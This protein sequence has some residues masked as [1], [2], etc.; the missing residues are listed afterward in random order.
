MLALSPLGR[1]NDANNAASVIVV[2]EVYRSCLGGRA[3]AHRREISRH[4]TKRLSLVC[5][6][7]RQS[8]HTVTGENQM[9]FGQLVMVAVVAAVVFSASQAEACFKK[10][11]KCCKP[12]CCEAAPTCCNAAPVSSCYAPAPVSTCCSA[13]V[14]EAAPCCA[15]APVAAPCCAPVVEAAPCCAPAPVSTCCD[16]APVSSCCAPAPVS[17]CAPAPSCCEPASCC[18]PPRQK[19]CKKQR[20]RKSRSRRSSCNSSPC[21]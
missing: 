21:C 6:R 2:F 18:K 17:C 13:P 7:S 16:V 12:V 15:P 20:C 14:V 8:S 10:R 9:K 19:R 5:D 3:N 11:N 1:K 4:L